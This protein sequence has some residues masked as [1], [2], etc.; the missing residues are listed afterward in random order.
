MMI[1]RLV[2]TQKKIERVKKTI[3]REEPDRIPVYDFL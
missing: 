3:N 1:T 2:D